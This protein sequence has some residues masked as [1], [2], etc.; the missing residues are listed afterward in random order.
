MDNTNEALQKSYARNAVEKLASAADLV[1]VQ[2]PPAK[3]TVR[4]RIPDNVESVNIS[5]HLIYFRVVTPQG[6][7]DVYAVTRG[8]VNGSISTTQGY[9][10]YVVE[11]LPGYVNI[12]GV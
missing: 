9:R 6:A 11:A 10:V 3:V 4:V 5:G 7:S 1:Y 2:G 8:P 12:S